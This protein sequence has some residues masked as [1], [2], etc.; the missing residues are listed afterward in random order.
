LLTA[1][2]FFYAGAVKDAANAIDIGLQKFPNDVRLTSAKGAV[3][4]E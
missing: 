1:L 2:G 4:V 3:V